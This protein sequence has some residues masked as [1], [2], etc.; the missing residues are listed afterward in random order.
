MEDVNRR[1]AAG[2]PVTSGE[3]ADWRRWAGLDDVAASSAARPG[4]RRAMEEKE[5]RRE[6]KKSRRT[7]SIRLPP[8]GLAFFSPW[9]RGAHLLCTSSRTS[10]LRVPLPP[11]LISSLATVSKAAFGERALGGGRPRSCVGP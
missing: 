1:M 7:S 9:S 3:S 6:K 8:L 11:F 5:K 10:V 2:L 4:P